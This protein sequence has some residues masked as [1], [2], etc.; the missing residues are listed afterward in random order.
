MKHMFT[1]HMQH[2]KSKRTAIQ[3]CNKALKLAL[4]IH[5]DL[6]GCK[7]K[8]LFFQRD[9]DSK[10]QESITEKYIQV[11]PEAAAEALLLAAKR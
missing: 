5:A 6:N 10:E 8:R 4:Y 11:I 2:Q 9:E 1:K 3:M 7:S